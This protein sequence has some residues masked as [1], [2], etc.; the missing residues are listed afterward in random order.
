DA[1]YVAFLKLVARQIAG[2]VVDAR[3]YEEERRR[4]DALAELDRAK[5]L[6]FTNVSHELR[7]P[8]T[9]ILSPLEELL[10]QP[11][12]ADP[13]ERR[14]RLEL[15]RRNA[16]RLLRL[17]N[18]LLDFSRAEAGRIEALFEPTDLAAVTHDLAAA[19]RSAVD[20][21]GLRL[22]VDCAPLPEPVYV[23]RDAWEKIVLNLLSNALK[24]TFEGEIAL[25]LAAAEGSVE[26]Q[27]RDTGVGIPPGELPHLFE[28]FHRVRGVRS[29]S[30]EG[31][32]IGLALVRELVELHG[33][34]V[35]VESAL[36][37]GTAFRVR[38]PLGSRHLPSDRIGAGDVGAPRGLGAAPYVEEALRWLPDA[39]P[40]EP[41][42]ELPLRDDVVR[43]AGAP[44]RAEARILVA[45]DNA[46]MRDYLARLLRR[47]WTVDTAADGEEALAAARCAPPDLVLSDVM[48]P[49]LDGFE[50]L[51]ALRSD[52]TTRSVPVVLVSARAGAESAVEGLEAGADDY[53]V[54]PFSARE[55]IA[56]VRTNLELSALRV[57]LATLGAV[58]EERARAERVLASLPE[59][60]AAVGGGVVELWNP[61]A[62]QVTGLPAAYAVGRP[63]EDV[64]PGWHELAE[65]LAE[66]PGQATAHPL[67]LAGRERWLS[68]V[69][70][71]HGEWTVLAFRDVTGA[72]ALEQA[73][74]DLVTTISHE[75]RTPVSSIYG[76]ATTLARTDLTL[77]EELRRRLTTTLHAETER[78]ARV[79]ESFA[80]VS[81][82][83]A[84]EDR[85]RRHCDVAPLVER[86]LARGRERC[87]AARL[88]AR[89]PDGCPPLPADPE[90]LEQVLD[91]LVDNGVRYSGPV[92]EVDLAYEPG[93]VRGRF[94]VRDNGIG[95]PPEHH[96]RIGEKFFRVDPELRGG[97]SGLGL[98]L[99]VATR[100]VELMDGKLWFE[101]APGN[102]S[103]FYVEL[104]AR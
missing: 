39:T 102:G 58:T 75:L 33:G 26:L 9:L 11:D 66:R 48:M 87:P 1:E 19:F 40:V 80:T 54:K 2:A 96:A 49:G 16:L 61:A 31:S 46:D 3:A 27:V 45:D 30:H 50:L 100:L 89:I 25:S 85:R 24:F 94:S 86:V 63:I 38:V 70:S 13:E 81:A 76:A 8:L 10:A 91:V 44:L 67:E 64:L 21:A 22:V 57:E 99:Y 23:D 32:G 18:A 53:L 37:A 74:N 6:F 95:I 93:E 51:R 103:T 92:A 12:A 97:V 69:S 83:D 101:S 4:A 7:T 88:A 15:I 42:E 98:G 20:A 73:R 104:P 34:T 71:P 55:L 78:L 28:R 47:H 59:A 29:R 72:R 41:Q 60:I 68:F 65:R 56:R 14:S 62:E 84:D 77:D 43:E 82:L 17:V 36:G 5:T 79:V 35:A 52:P 90:K